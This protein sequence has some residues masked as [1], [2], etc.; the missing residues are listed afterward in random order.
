MRA[1][2]T[3]YFAVDSAGDLADYYRWRRA[4]SLGDSATRRQIRRILFSEYVALGVLGSLTG[5]VLAFGGAWALMHFVF[6]ST[7]SASLGTPLLIAMAMLALTVSIGLLS[8]RDVFNE[9]PMGALR[10]V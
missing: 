5:M 8:G 7:F 4:V 1:L 3:R 2:S 6:E 9:T 10:E